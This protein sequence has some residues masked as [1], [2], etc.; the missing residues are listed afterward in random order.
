MQRGRPEEAIGPPTPSAPFGWRVTKGNR[1]VQGALAL[2]REAGG[3][4]FG[5]VRR[6]EAER[7]PRSRS[8]I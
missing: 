1:P 4:G 5:P 3:G 8:V 6:E 2:A 7:G